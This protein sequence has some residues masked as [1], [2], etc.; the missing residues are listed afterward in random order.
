LHTPELDGAILPGVTRDS[1]LTLG[2]HLGYKV[3]ERRMALHELLAQIDSGEC[4][5]VF[6]SGTAA[7]VSP[8]GVLAD[9]AREYVPQRID[10]VAA[11]LREALLAIQERRASDPFGWIRDV[12]AFAA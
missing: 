6:A 7:T 9:A 4:S 5:E 3:V 8:I 1:L 10:A 11:A 2:P 12:P